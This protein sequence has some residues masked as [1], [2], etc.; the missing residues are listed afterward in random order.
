MVRISVH[1]GAM[2]L[3][4]LGIAWVGDL[5]A[6]CASPQSLNHKVGIELGKG[7]KIDEIIDSMNMVAEGVKSCKPLHELGTEADVWMP[8]TEN[9]TRICHEDATVEEVVSDLLKREIRSEFAGIEEYLTFH[10]D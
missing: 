9:V 2:P 10:G 7:R 8:I 1:F 3:T 4:L 5:I 6:T